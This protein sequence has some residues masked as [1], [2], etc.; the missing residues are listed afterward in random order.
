[1]YFHSKVHSPLWFFFLLCTPR[2]FTFC[3]ISSLIRLFPVLQVL[4]SLA[5][6]NI[7]VLQVQISRFRFKYPG[8]GSNIRLQFN[9]KLLVQFYHTG[10][11]HLI[12]HELVYEFGFNFFSQFINLLSAHQVSSRL[13]LAR[14]FQHL[15]LVQNLTI[16]D[17]CFS[18]AWVN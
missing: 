14:H 13:T 8:S 15:Q 5:D 18:S 17:H 11:L 12:F 7:Q 2:D 4:I 1:M 6:S 10:S 9:L 16:S 3:V